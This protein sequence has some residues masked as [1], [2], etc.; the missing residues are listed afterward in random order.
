MPVSVK[1][2]HGVLVMSILVTTAVLLSPPS[3]SVAQKPPNADVAAELDTAKAEA[4]ELARDAD[5]MT[6]LIQSDVSWESHADALTRIKEHVNNMGKIVAKLQEER[7]QASPWQQQAIDRMI[8][9]LKEI[10][11]NTT[12]AIE[13]LNAN[14]TRPVSGNYKDYLDQNPDTSLQLADMISSFEQYGRTRTKLEQ[15][16]D[17]LELPSS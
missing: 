12:R 14:H 8:P 5:E 15:L 7:G 10:A 6:S 1:T 4:A 2:K 3:R 16:Q 17:K 9:M 13:H 11:A